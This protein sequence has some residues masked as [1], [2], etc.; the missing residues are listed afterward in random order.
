M[1]GAFVAFRPVGVATTGP[2]V[3]DPGP[4]SRFRRVTR[5]F[6]AVHSVPETHREGDSQG[7]QNVVYTLFGAAEVAG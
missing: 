5:L 2:G 6:G 4:P 1:L 7:Y 3:S